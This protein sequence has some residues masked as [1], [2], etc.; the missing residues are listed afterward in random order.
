[1]CSGGPILTIQ[2]SNL[3][4]D[5]AIIDKGGQVGAAK[6]SLKETRRRTEG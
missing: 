5:G 1:M 6:R 2:K 4:E 3:S